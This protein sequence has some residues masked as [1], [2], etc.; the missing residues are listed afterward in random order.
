MVSARRNP[1]PTNE[2]TGLEGRFRVIEEI[3]DAILNLVWEYKL[4]LHHI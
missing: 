4:T 3:E 2:R 1:G